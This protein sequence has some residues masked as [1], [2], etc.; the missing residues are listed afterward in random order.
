MTNIRTKK[1]TNVINNPLKTYGFDVLEYFNASRNHLKKNKTLHNQ[2]KQ[3]N[4]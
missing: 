3:K 4:K 1:K 2:K